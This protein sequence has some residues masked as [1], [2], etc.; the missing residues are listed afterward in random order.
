M[1]TRSYTT[2]IQNANFK[3]YKKTAM[4]ERTPK[5]NS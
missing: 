3:Q 2:Q 5:S 1:L 4:K